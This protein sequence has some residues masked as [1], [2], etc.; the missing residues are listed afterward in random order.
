MSGWPKY[1][2]AFIG[3]SVT[4]DGPFPSDMNG[5]PDH[6]WVG[7]GIKN[8]SRPSNSFWISFLHD[9]WGGPGTGDDMPWLYT[10]SVHGSENGNLIGQRTGGGIVQMVNALENRKPMWVT[11]M[12]GHND[13]A[14]WNYVLRTEWD[15]L[16]DKALENNV[17]PMIITINP[18]SGTWAHDGRVPGYNDSLKKWARERNLPIIDWYGALVDPSIGNCLARADTCTRDGVHPLRATAESNTIGAAS[19]FSDK[20]ILF[21]ANGDLSYDGIS[22]M[23]ILNVMVLE[24]SYELNEK[25]VRVVDSDNGTTPP[26]S[27][28]VTDEKPDTGSGSATAGPE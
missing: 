16:A 5:A 18:S 6:V 19:D 20:N 2:M 23:G 15:A 3:D 17:M 11:I 22:M 14:V 24:M 26:A 21:S 25:V 13:R 28:I 4:A 1:R 9:T 8:C 27:A 12:F 7:P 10:T